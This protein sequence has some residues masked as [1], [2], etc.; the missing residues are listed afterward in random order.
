M[1]HALLGRRGQLADPPL[2][3]AVK[4][5][6][7]APDANGL[8][9][10]GSLRNESKARLHH[11]RLR[12]SADSTAAWLKVRT[13]SQLSHSPDERSLR[14]DTEP[15]AAIERVHCMR[16]RSVEGIGHSLAT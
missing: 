5:P 10:V 13:D 3:S 4:R 2:L 12:I 16:V 6:Y 11:T 8:S 9:G 14:A 1:I 7:S 15:L